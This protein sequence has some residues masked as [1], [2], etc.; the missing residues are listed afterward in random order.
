V[1]ARRQTRRAPALRLAQP[2]AAGAALLPQ[3][4]VRTAG[5]VRELSD[6]GLIVRMTSGRLWIG[7]LCGLLGGIVALNVLSLGLNASSG[8][9]SQRI[10]GLERSNSALRAELGE[11]LSASR[12]E[13]AAARLGLIVP[14]PEEITYL[15][16]AD[17]EVNRVEGVAGEPPASTAVPVEP[18]PLSPVAPVIEVP[19]A[20]PPAPTPEAESPVPAPPTGG[21]SGG[22]APA[23]GVSP[24]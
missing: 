22:T 19:E 1:T 20:E 6:S 10:E 21:E 7:V 11:R 3:A 24:G 15:E 4:A 17:G 13:A 8:R 12:I 2:A 16:L 14:A 23:G 5:A 18:Q 9:V